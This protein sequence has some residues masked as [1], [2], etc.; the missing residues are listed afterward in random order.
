MNVSSDQLSGVWLSLL[1]GCT[2]SGDV[3]PSRSV[4]SDTGSPVHTGIGTTSTDG[5]VS[6]AAELAPLFAARCTICHYAGSAGDYDMNDLWNPES[7]MV[8]RPNSWATDGSDEPVLIDPGNPDGSF[9]MVK[10]TA[11]AIT[12][13]AVDGNPMP[14]LPAPLTPEEIEQVEEWIDD[15]ARDDRTYRDDVEPLFGTEITLGRKSGRCTWCH[16]PGA[17]NGLDILDVFDPV[18]G[19]VNRPSASGGFIV[20]PDEAAN[21]VLMERLRGKG[22]GEPMPQQLPMFTADQVALIRQWIAEGALDN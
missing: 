3:T 1:I 16:Y 4:A 14:Y 8:G 10:I 22:V 17:A 20:V 11:G 9:L 7:G 18:T 19:M 6:Y 15:G 21:S 2:S 12:D 13:I 5:G